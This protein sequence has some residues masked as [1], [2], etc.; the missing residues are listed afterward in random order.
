MKKH[1]PINK[2]PQNKLKES[3]AKAR[4]ENNIGLALI[5]F[6]NTPLYIITTKNLN[7][8]DCY[9]AK[10][11]QGKEYKC[12]TVSENIEQLKFNDYSVRHL[13]GAQ[14]IQDIGRKYEVLIAYDD[15]GDYLTKNH[16]SWFL[17]IMEK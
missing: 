8:E 5:E 2:L 17:D 6:W 3:F 14:I 4:L 12:V 16:L 15:G 10:V 9:A 1:L 13:T 7:G 11:A